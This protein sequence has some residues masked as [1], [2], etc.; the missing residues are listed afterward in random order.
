ML[1]ITVSKKSI[2]FD[3]KITLFPAYRQAQEIM[4]ELTHEAQYMD[5]GRFG[6]LARYIKEWIK[7]GFDYTEMK[8]FGLEKEALDVELKFR[9]LVA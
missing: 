1:G 2:L 8:K 9:N 6:F 4:H 7:S 3:P 5:Y